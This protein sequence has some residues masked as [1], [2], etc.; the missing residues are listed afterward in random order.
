MRR[1]LDIV[2]LRWRSLSRRGAADRDLDRELRFHLDRRVEELVAEGCSTRE[3]HDRA[4]REFG[5]P[6]SVAEQCRDTR[7]V[8][9]LQHI[10]QDLRYGARV[11]R[12]QPMLLVAATT[13]IALG[14]G[15]NLTI[16]GLA[17][18][19]LLSQPTARDAG[20]LVHIRTTNGSHVSY[21]VWREL[22]AADVIGGLAGYDIE[23]DMVWRDRDASVTLTP[24]LVT[25]NFFDVL[26]IPIALGRGFTADEAAAELSPRLAVVSDAFWRRRLGANPSVVGTAITLDGAPYTVLG[27]LPADLRSLPGYGFMP[28]V[29]VPLSRTL[30][31]TLDRIRATHVQLIGRLR[32]G[33]SAASAQAALG[34]VASGVAAQ[35]GDPEAG[36]IRTVAHV[37]GL[38]QLKDFEQVALFFGVLLIVTALVLVIACANVAGL[39]LSR[40]A[41]RRR[42]IA[43]RLALGASRRRLVQ[44][45]LTEGV[46]LAV[47]GTGAGLLLTEGFARLARGLVIELPLRVAPQWSFD[48]RMLWAAAGMVILSSLLCGLAPALQATRSSLMPG[49]KQD[50]IAALHRRFHLRGWL[51]LG[52]VTISMLLLVITALFLRNLGLAERLS[53]G[54]DSAR[55]VLAQVT[56]VTADAQKMAA[57]LDSVRAL[58][59][60]EAVSFAAGVPLT[61]RYGGES[62]MH[63]RIDGREQRVR[64]DFFQNDVGPAYFETMGLRIVRGRGFSPS[65]TTGTPRVVVINE[66]FARRYLEG[67]DPIGRHIY[68]PQRAQEESAQIIGVVSDSKYRTIGEDRSAAIYGAALQ[69]GAARFTNIIVRTAL[70]P[71][72]L[73]TPVSAAIMRLDASAAVSV[74]PMTSALRF[75]LLPSRA[76][77]ALMGALG[78]LGTVLAMIGLYGVVAFAVSRRTSEIGIRV[79]LGAS[80]ATVMR[81]V[82]KEGGVLVAIGVAA[83]LVL[84]LMVTP[85]LRAF[86]VA[87]LPTTDP[88][89][90]AGTALLLAA[91]SAAAIFGPARRALRVE[92]AVSLRVD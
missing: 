77:A 66:E 76:G 5:S 18:S 20:D 49:L 83:G 70:P 39:L 31:P 7:R 65:E 81:L 28:D 74:E 92:P 11:L 78:V 25:A 44:Q 90:F 36:S 41:A 35:Y 59:G 24:L 33:Q 89:S 54:F 34:A 55:T 67:L 8:H 26:G 29:Y 3:A 9:V 27:V 79:A 14:V 91:T 12:A 2:R 62:G 57:V 86:L 1:W 60:V 85:A 32:P 88:V 13:S 47:L 30:I 63:M 38:S 22:A 75:A 17:N 87:D 23:T 46:L 19:I 73:V 61:M 52:Q 16:F 43:L 4:L 84:A 53:P 71:E 40:A 82:M 51:V 68:L 15:A 21:T 58:P 45:L 42:E 56:F 72:S 50:A 80:R 48:A 10:L 69:H 64:V 37:G 6:S